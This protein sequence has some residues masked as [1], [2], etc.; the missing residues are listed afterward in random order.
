MEDAGEVDGAA[1][2]EDGGDP[3]DGGPP[4]VTARWGRRSCSATVRFAARPGASVVQMAGDF[5]GWGDAPLAMTDPDDDGVFEIRLGPETGLVPGTLH[6]YR[7]IVDGEYLLDPTAAHRKYDGDCINSGLLAPACDAGPEIVPGR[8]MTAHDASTGRGSASV[9]LAILTALDGAAPSSVRFE[10]DGALLDARMA[11]LDEDAGA[12]DVALAGLE[13]GRHLLSVRA[14][15]DRGREAA[16][17][18]LPFWIEARAFD[19]RDATMYMIVVDRFANGDRASDAPVGAPVE[20]PAD[21]HGGD[22]QGIT[23]VM[24]SGYFEQMGANV[25]WLSPINDQAEG[26]FEGRDDA[27]R[28][29]GYHGYWPERGR[30]V[31]P[32]FGGDAALHALIDEAHSRGI[33]V[34]LDL[35]NNQVH[36]QHEYFTA[37]PE[38]F[39]TGCVCGIDAGCGW[40]ERPLDC[41]FAP[42]LP[43]INWRVPAAEAQFTDDALYWIEEFGID[44]F[45]IDAVKHVETNSI[46]NLRAATARR[47]EQGG[48]RHYFVGETAVTEGD[49]VD[50]GCGERFGNGYEWLDGYVGERA[51]DGQ[52]DFPSHHR[53]GG[54]IDGTMGFD[55]VESV[56]RDAQTRLRPEGLHVRFLGTH[57]S[58]RI[59]SRAAMDGRAGCRWLEGGCASLPDASSDPAVYARLRRALAVLYTMPGIPFLYYGDELA[60]PG[61][62]DPDNRRD[63]IWEGALAGVSMSSEMPSAEQR[64][65]RDFVAAVGRAR[66]ESVAIRRGRRVA[67]IAESNLYVVAWIGE[68]SGELALMI[69]NRGGAI[70]G[71]GI[72]GLTAGQLEGIASFERAAGLGGALVRGTGSRLTL[73]LP[74]GEAAIFIAR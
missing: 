13:E 73:D 69:A 25:L 68:R 47:F 37:N 39:R 38:W 15:D 9:R 29:A 12:Y 59:A 60:M 61:G 52:F 24:R 22:L 70:S 64:A 41:L 62:G 2:G 66:A 50:Y 27:H 33:R 40:S 16:P 65:L 10:L 3:I 56:V 21:F 51:L 57:D 8:L 74:A 45:R 34:L 53:M 58:S 54:L 23:E 5:T 20:Y 67:L 6:A 43:D 44:G 48:Y 19:W 4:P 1:P 36:E 7:V 17:I 49:A 42:Y 28:Y 30:A 63:M 35:I 26:H 11:V 71:R 14:T 55:A 31:E 72:D 46:V 32:R 18:D